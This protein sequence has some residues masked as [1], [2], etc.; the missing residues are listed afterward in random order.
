MTR[1]QK[2]LAVIDVLKEAIA[3]AGY[4]AWVKDHVYHEIAEKI[5][6]ALEEDE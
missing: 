4:A 1:S 2:L 3:E 5:V 6:D